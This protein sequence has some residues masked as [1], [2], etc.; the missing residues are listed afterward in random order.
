MKAARMKLRVAP[1]VRNILDR[2]GKKSLDV[3]VPHYALERQ[4][5]PTKPSPDTCLNALWRVPTPEGPGTGA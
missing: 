4:V 5:L 1:P 2:V 3:D